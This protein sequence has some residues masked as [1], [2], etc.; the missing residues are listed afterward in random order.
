MKTLAKLKRD[1]EQMYDV[2]SK[3]A[4]IW[5]TTS[6]DEEGNLWIHY[7]DGMDERVPKVEFRDYQKETQRHLFVDGYKRL[8]LCRPRRAGK[9]VESW[10]ILVQGAIVEPGL[11]IMVYPTS[12]RARSILWE[13]DM[14]MP[15][16]SS[17][18]FL[19]M[20]PK[21]LV[22][23]TKN[24]E[25]KVY[26]ANGSIIWVMG[27]NVDEDKLRG[28]NPRGAVFS[29]HAFQDEY[30][31]FNILPVMR[32]NGGWIICQS[33]FNG[34]NHFYQL[35]ENNRENPHW[36]T[37]VDSIETLT[38]KEG[39]PYITEDDVDADRKTG[40]PEFKIQQE[41]YSVVLMNEESHYFAQQMQAMEDQGRL[42]TGIYIPEAPLYTAWDLGGSGKDADRTFIVFFQLVPKKHFNEILVVGSMQGQ[43]KTRNW[44]LDQVRQ[45]ANRY[46]LSI[47]CHLAPHDGRN[48]TF[49]VDEDIVQ[50]GH[51]NC[52]QFLVAPKPHDKQTAIEMMREYLYRTKIDKIEADSLVESLRAYHKEYDTDL[53]RYK[54][55]PVH[56]WSSHGVDAYQTLVLGLHGGMIQTRP[57]EIMYYA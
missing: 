5:Y 13:G 55:K 10:N 45:F 18:R 42:E 38:D 51:S 16:G 50:W 54:S 3:H 43:N 39:N 8:A 23:S 52:E 30:V 48:K 47:A 17:Y 12:V 40:M 25:M 44:F 11:Y 4:S 37:R 41:Y 57:M 24:D 9:E 14:K 19:D 7:Q 27:S 32:Q 20:V 46:N 21:R 35:I 29:E 53:A 15:N 36:I 1:V 31:F 34:K 22:T 49:N 33:T 26:L 2:V 6:R 28:T 56:D